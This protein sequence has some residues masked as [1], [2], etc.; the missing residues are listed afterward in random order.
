MSDGVGETH[1]VACWPLLGFQGLSRARVGSGE[2]AHGLEDGATKGSYCVGWLTLTGC[3]ERC[4]RSEDRA[5]RWNVESR[6][7]R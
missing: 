4:S 7:L 1:D 5:M 3:G 2:A 6:V